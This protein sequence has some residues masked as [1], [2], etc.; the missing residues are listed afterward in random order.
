MDRNNPASQQE[1]PGFLDRLRST[2]NALSLVT[3]VFATFAEVAMFRT[4]FG[5]RY[6]HGWTT[7]LVLP[8]LLLFPLF[9]PQHDPM[10]MLLCFVLYVLMCAAHRISI[11]R[12]RRRP[13]MQIH[14]LYNGVSRLQRVWPRVSEHDLKS[15][16]E[17]A[18]MLFFGLCA[19]TFSPPLG[20]FFI[21]CA[22]SMA[23]Q[24]ALLIANR[25]QRE[26]DLV[27]ARIEGQLIA[28]ASNEPPRPAVPVTGDVVTIHKE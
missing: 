6:F 13:D 21:C 15:K 19:L 3:G 17:P 1:Q 18:V 10:P 25:R 24:A 27:D 28:G 4:T 16:S 20:W 7:G 9:W 5:E 12:R 2:T 26:L 11:Y 14:S 8:L 22:V 23:A